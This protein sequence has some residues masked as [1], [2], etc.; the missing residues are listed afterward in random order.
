MERL[1][2]LEAEREAC[3]RKVS[4]AKEQMRGLWR[5]V[6]A[7]KVKLQKYEQV[8]EENRELRQT[9]GEL[10]W[11]FGAAEQAVQEL[12]DLKAAPPE[13]SPSECSVPNSRATL[14]VNSCSDHEDEE[15]VDRVLMDELWRERDKSQ[16]MKRVDSHDSVQCT[17]EA[18]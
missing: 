16:R 4:W 6:H 17:P 9:V 1:T 12:N 10:T 18:C 2:Y 7:L 5:Q 3:V 11:A 13:S 8:E 14:S 15:D